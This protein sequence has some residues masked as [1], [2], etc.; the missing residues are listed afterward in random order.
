MAG[1]FH[2]D[3]IPAWSDLVTLVRILLDHDDAA[4]RRLLKAVYDSL[5]PGGTVLIAEPMSGVRGAEPISDAYF[6]F[7][8]LAMGR[9]RTRHVEEVQ[10]LLTE[11][12]FEQAKLVPTR[13]ALMTQLVVAVKK[14]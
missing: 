6:G 7:Y 3:P 14:A 5:P 2:R 1:D 4:V 13:R 10:G 11:A 9:G 12:G 8:L